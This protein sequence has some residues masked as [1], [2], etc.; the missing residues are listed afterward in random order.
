MGFIKWLQSLFTKK[1]DIPKEEE[2]KST[3]SNDT[4]N[5]GNMNTPW[6]DAAKKMEG[7]KET[8]PKVQAIMVPLWKKIYNRSL[9]SIVA[10]AWCGLGMGAAF[11]WSGLPVQPKGEMA[12]NWSLY[13]VAVDYKV[14]GVPKTA[15]VRLNHNGDCSLKSSGNHV[16]TANGSCAPQDFMEKSIKKDGSVEYVLK[17]NAT[18]D[19]YGANQGNEWKVTTYKMSEICDVRWVDQKECLK[20]YPGAAFCQLPGNVE[21]SVNCTSAKTGKESTK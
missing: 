19:L 15:I 11:F 17:K 20:V 13:G 16:T 18:I 1:A 10:F 7:S 21:K 14:M 4:L 3:A 9:S 12:A 5:P 8:D 6:G 2:G